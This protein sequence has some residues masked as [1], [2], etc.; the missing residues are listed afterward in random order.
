MKTVLSAGCKAVDVVG[1][2]ECT[3]C[4]RAVHAAHGI[5]DYLAEGKS[6]FL[7][8]NRE[9]YV[10]HRTNGIP[11]EG[12]IFKGEGKGTFL[13]GHIVNTGTEQNKLGH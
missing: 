1:D 3:N 2:A 12:N 6:A 11:A 5:D 4:Q 10:E 7:H 8:H 9:G 13:S